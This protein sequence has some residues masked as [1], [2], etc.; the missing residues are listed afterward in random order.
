[1]P[2]S[3]NRKKRKGPFTGP[4]LPTMREIEQLAHSLDT[5]EMRELYRR[6]KKINPNLDADCDKMT[7]EIQEIFNHGDKPSKK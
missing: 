1:M 6:Q 5:P 2:K 4:K 7:E 3:R